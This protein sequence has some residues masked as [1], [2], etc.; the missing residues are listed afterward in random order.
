MDSFQVVFE[1]GQVSSKSGGKGKTQK[2]EQKPTWV[3]QLSSSLFVCFKRLISY[4]FTT[5]T[6]SLLLGT[7]IMKRCFTKHTHLETTSLLD[8]E[9]FKR[10]LPQNKTKQKNM[11]VNNHLWQKLLQF[12]QDLCLT[13]SELVV[14]RDLLRANMH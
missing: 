6:S 11:R 2:K 7:I 12:I 4:K 14:Q 3:H 8:F 5:W 13:S 10:S 1:E 9:S